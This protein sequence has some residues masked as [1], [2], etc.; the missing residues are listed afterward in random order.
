ML[1]GSRPSTRPYG[2]DQLAALHVALRVG[3]EIFELH[4]AA[5]FLLPGVDDG[6]ADADLV[7]VLLE[8]A[9][10]LGCGSTS[11]PLRVIR[12]ES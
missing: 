5:L 2:R 10:A 8:D 7:G 6:E 9:L 3:A 4:R 1:C 12:I 11:V